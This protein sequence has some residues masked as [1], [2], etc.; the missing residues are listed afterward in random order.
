MLIHE[1]LSM[2]V[3]IGLPIPTSSNPCP[4]TNIFLRKLQ[5]KILSMK[6]STTL[7]DADPSKKRKTNADTPPLLQLK[8]IY[9]EL[10]D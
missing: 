10:I 3:V 6:I 8:C 2:T 7:V 9:Y 1:K 5:A 4:S